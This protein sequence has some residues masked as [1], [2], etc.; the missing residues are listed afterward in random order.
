MTGALSHIRV[1]DLS[2]VLAGPTATQVLGDLGAEVIK[3]ERPGSGDD[4]REWGPPYLKTAAGADTPESAYYACVNRNKKSVTVDLAKPAGQDLIRRLAGKCDVLIENYKVG[5][6]ARYG[7]DY[8][9]LARRHPRLI[10]CSI[11]G[12]GQTGPYR[13]RAGYDPI[14]QAMGGLMSITGESDARPGGGPQRVGISISDLMTGAYAVIGILAALVYR[15]ESGRGQQVDAALLDVLV[16][17]LSNAAMNYLVTGEV[18]RRQGNAHPNVVPSGAFA[19]SDGRL[20]FVAGNDSQFV[21]LCE[22]LGVAELARDPRFASNA[23]RVANRDA[24]NALLEAATCRRST[25]EL[26]EALA[27]AGVP[28]GPINDMAQVFADPQVVARGLRIDLDHPLAGTIPAIA[29]PVRLSETPA[30][31][32]LPPPLL[33][34]HTREVLRDLLGMSEAEIEALAGAKAI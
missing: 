6:L 22:V 28:A 15:N 5:T 11:T 18:P 30:Q 31:Y 4:S 20:Q 14:M 2:R 12:F 34:Q 21:K 27:R 29:S 3:I 13:E 19:C 16:A 33:G 7:L 10:Y 17:A 8:P 1:L 9:T 24:I 26:S 25:G 23:V 32:R